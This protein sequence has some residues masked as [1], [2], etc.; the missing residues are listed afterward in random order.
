MASI[1]EKQ[2]GDAFNGQMVE[3]QPTTTQA[4]AKDSGRKQKQQIQHEKAAT[5]SEKGKR[6]G[7]SYKALYQGLQNP[8]HS[9]GGQGKCIS[10]DQ[11]ND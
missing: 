7:L 9:A 2:K 5:S 6:Q 11:N 1:D 8:K 10:D 4:S 3:K